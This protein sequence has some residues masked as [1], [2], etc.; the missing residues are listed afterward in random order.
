MIIQSYLRFVH[1]LN[2]WS[3]KLAGWLSSLLVVIICIDVLLRYVFQFSTVA[4][5]DTEWHLFALIFLLGAGYTLQH[6]RHVRVGVFYAK[7]SPRQQAWVNVLGCLLFLFPFSL[8]LVP[9]SIMNGN[10]AGGK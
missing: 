7:F 8:L 6:D 10:H 1:R 9:F 5:Y 4:L 2:H 3:G